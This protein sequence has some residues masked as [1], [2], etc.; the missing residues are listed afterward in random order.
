MDE[1]AFHFH[2]TGLA[3]RSIEQEARW[4]SILGYVREGP[5]FTDP[6]Q[7]ITGQFMVLGNTRVELLESLPD[8]RVL[9]NWLARGSPIYHFAFEVAHLEESLD[10]LEASGAKVISDPKPAVAF[11][12]RR[13]AF[14]IRRNRMVVELIESELG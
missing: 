7:G 14:T 9:D 6:L 2:H 4:F 10:R 11:G 13:V 1:S 8:A 12:G 5:T 3:C